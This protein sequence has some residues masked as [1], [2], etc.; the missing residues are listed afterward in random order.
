MEGE[1]SGAAAS[2]RGRREAKGRSIKC[3][4]PIRNLKYIWMPLW[5][6]VHLSTGDSSLLPIGWLPVWL[7][8][9]T[10]PGAAMGFRLLI[11]DHFY[12]QRFYFLLICDIRLV[13]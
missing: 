6:A 12:A 4:I 2:V 8:S 1:V 10:A 11:E 5:G 9:Y 13:H 7:M 3:I